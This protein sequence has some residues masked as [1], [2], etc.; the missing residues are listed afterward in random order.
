M[1]HPHCRDLLAELSAYLD[2]EA[3]QSVCAEIERHLQSCPDCCAV[4]NTLDHTVALDRALPAPG[5]PA[6]VEERLLRLLPL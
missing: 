1:A 6:G 2:G 3:A 5:F 4:V